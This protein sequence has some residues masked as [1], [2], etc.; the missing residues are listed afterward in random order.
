[1]WVEY[2]GSTR[3]TVANALMFLPHIS[4]YN[5]LS[6]FSLSSPRLSNTSNMVTL[7]RNIDSY[8]PTTQRDA[9]SLAVDRSDQQQPS[10]VEFRSSECIALARYTSVPVIRFLPARLV[11]I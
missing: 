4:L 1:V 10:P 9:E 8:P 3:T 5:S 2:H 7:R 6:T 11:S